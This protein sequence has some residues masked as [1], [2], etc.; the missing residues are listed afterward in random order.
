M[1]HV[2]AV[3]PTDAQAWAAMR[4][5]LWPES[6]QAE[7]REEIAQFFA[8]AFPRGPWAALVAEDSDGELVGF[9]EVSTRPYVEGCSTTPAAYLEGWWVAASHRQRGVG[10]ALVAAAEAWGRAQG[11]TEFGSDAEADN[12]VSCAAHRALGFED[13][14]LVRCFAKKL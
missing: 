6:P 10:A 14:G 11:C 5:A 3:T 9:V 8:G 7:H 2:R 12:E 4:T 1:Q 13:H